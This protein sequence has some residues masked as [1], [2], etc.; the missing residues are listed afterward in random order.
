MSDLRSQ[1]CNNELDPS[2][3]AAST[4]ISPFET[5]VPASEGITSTSSATVHASATPT[6]AHISTPF[7]S[8]PTISSGLSVP[9]KAGL[10][11]GLT[12]IVLAIFIIILEACYLRPRRR[13]RAL[14]RAVA[15]VE[16]ASGV[17]MKTMVES[18][19]SGSKETMVLESR[20]EILVEGEES[21]DEWSVDDD[22]GEEWDADV[23]DEERG[24]RGGRN[25][26]SLPRRLY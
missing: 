10:I 13:A 4:H 20:V 8:P 22:D 9:A 5:L 11:S 17:D 14:R 3:T 15:E 21:E 23:E 18:I 24:R 19:A 12:I 25:G 26:M 2:V 16:Q 7:P 1:G 6:S